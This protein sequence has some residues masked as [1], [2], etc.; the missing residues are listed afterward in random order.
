MEQLA[1]FASVVLSS[2]HIQSSDIRLYGQYFN[3]QSPHH[4]TYLSSFII[5]VTPPTNT[6]VRLWFECWETMASTLAWFLLFLCWINCVH[7]RVLSSEQLVV[8][9]W[10]VTLRGGWHFD[11]SSIFP[12]EKAPSS[13]RVQQEDKVVKRRFWGSKID[14]TCSICDDGTFYLTPLVP[15]PSSKPLALRGRWKV[16]SNPYC[17][18]DRF[19]DQVAMH[20][21]PRQ[22][23]KEGEILDEMK[24][25]LTCRLWG[26]YSR[27][28]KRRRGRLT[29]GSLCVSHESKKSRWKL[30]TRPVLASFSAS[31]FSREPIKEGWEDKA[32]FGY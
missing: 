7:A 24:F 29:H 11:P 26:R 27:E 18:T 3:E 9:E 19:Y 16:L 2:N 28:G 32:F 8:G 22:L 25:S 15:A 21:Y 12:T 31:Q 17:I 13:S 4:H 10:N 1:L 14:C 30:P 6:P 20:S 5:A 23:V